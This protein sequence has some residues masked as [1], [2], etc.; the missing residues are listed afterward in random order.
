MSRREKKNWN[1]DVKPILLNGRSRKCENRD[2][3]IDHEVIIKAV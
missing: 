3:A 1:V 2:L